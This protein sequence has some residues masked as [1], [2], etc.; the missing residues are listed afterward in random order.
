MKYVF[1]LVILLCLPKNAGSNY[2][3]IAGPVRVIEIKEGKIIVIPRPKR[4][5]QLY[6]F[7]AS[8][9]KEKNPLYTTELLASCKY[10]EIMTAIASIES[11]FYSGAV[12]DLNERTKWQILEWTKEDIR[13]DRSALNKAIQIFEEKKKNRNVVDAIKAY[14]GRGRKA[15]IYRRKVLEKIQEIKNMKV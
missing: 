4:F 8:H 5:K 9:P 14:N 10:P 12:G 11:G 7:I 15:E 1:L 3:R 13:N 2:V 6:Y